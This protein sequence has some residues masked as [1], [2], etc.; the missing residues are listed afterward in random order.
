MNKRAVVEVKDN[1]LVR[2]WSSIYKASKE[3]YL[4]RQTIMNY[5]NG[6]TKN[7]Q[8]DLRWKEQNEN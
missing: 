4:T 7:K 1:K 6:K 5:C 2:E 3:L 8:I